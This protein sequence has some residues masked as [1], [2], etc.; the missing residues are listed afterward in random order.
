VPTISGGYLALPSPG[1]LAPDRFASLHSPL[2]T[3]V[4]CSAGAPKIEIAA[5]AFASWLR[6]TS[7]LEE[8]MFIS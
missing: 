3:R 8:I 5:L 6:N 4:G 1:P 2:V 7:R